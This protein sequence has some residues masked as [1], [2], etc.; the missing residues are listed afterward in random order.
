VAS[1]GNSCPAISHNNL[2]SP[3]CD[4]ANRQAWG[5]NIKDNYSDGFQSIHASKLNVD[6]VLL[7]LQ[8]FHLPFS[9]IQK[10]M[11]C[12]LAAVRAFTN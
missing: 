1:R 5:S 7:H 2:S 10:K 3:A 8:Q 11:K 9:T 6:P 12:H 4:R